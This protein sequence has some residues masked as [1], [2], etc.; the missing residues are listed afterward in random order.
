MHRHP[1]GYRS[2][3]GAAALFCV[4]LANLAVAGALALVLAFLW[5]S[6]R[7]T[8]ASAVEGPQQVIVGPEDQLLPS[9]NADYLIWTANSEAFP[10][11][12]HAYGRPRGTNDGFRLNPS[13]TRGYAGGLD[14]GQNVAI[15]QQIEGSSSDLYRMN[16][17]TRERNPLP[18]AVN[19]ARWEWGPRV[20]D[21][22]YFFARDAGTSTTLFLYGRDTQMLE[23]VA[24][25]DLTSYYASPGAVGERYATWSVCGPVTCRA[26]VRDTETDET[27]KIPAPD[28]TARYAPVVDEGNEH[29]YVVRSGPRCGGA[30]RIVR[31]PLSDL[32]ATPVTIATL[33][34]GIDVGF[35]LSLE[36]RPTQLDLWF[37][38]YRCGPQQGD[39][40]R[41][42]DVGTV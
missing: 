13:G 30:V 12:Y 24:R 42:R 22:F 7:P 5:P 15:Y 33:P 1:A 28:G 36:E 27:R 20:S 21:T 3:A 38:R 26:F 23:K 32:G 9:A 25:Y 31:V 41:L 18:P 19:S 16:L 11:R 2:H 34:A 6:L 8:A 17:A 37:S 10:D 29:V 35:T 4:I 14:P 40:Y 39:V